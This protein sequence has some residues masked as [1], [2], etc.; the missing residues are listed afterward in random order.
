MKYIISV[1]PGK[2]GTKCVGRSIASTQD[3]EVYFPTRY[4]DLR[5]G[6]L[7]VEG[8]SYKVSQQKRGTIYHR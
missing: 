2:D 8:K 3:K 6:H 4:Y 1:D 5:N 7:E